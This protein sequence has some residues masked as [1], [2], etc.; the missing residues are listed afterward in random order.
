MRNESGGDGGDCKT[1]KKY[2]KNQEKIQ[3]QN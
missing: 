2:V 1:L 3:L